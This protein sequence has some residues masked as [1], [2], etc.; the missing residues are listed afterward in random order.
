MFNN[1]LNKTI[2]QA[3]EFEKSAK[4]PLTETHFKH[5]K[6]EY[7][8]AMKKR[9]FASTLLVFMWKCAIDSMWLTFLGW[10]GARI[11]AEYCVYCSTSP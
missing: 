9:S 5:V 1:Y 8:K 2:N 3:Y 10:Q 6:N 7:K 11:L 4:H